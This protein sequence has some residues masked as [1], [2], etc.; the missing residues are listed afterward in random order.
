MLT[1]RWRLA[2]EDWQER[3]YHDD[4]LQEVMDR[5][6][7]RFGNPAIDLGGPVEA[8][9]SRLPQQRLRKKKRA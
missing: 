7:Q 5:A 9:P 8:E 4:R 1:V 2:G 6:N 3:E